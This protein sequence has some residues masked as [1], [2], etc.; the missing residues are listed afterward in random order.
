MK[1][2]WYLLFCLGICEDR[3]ACRSSFH[4]YGETWKYAGGEANPVS[5]YEAF[6]ERK[7]RPQQFPLLTEASEKLEKGK[8][9]R[10]TGDNL[11]F[12]GSST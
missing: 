7:E 10:A 4:Q 8:S 12:S 1:R 3:I 5:V 11:E 6:R 2:D 9:D